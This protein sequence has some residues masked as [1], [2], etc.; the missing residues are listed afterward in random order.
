MPPSEAVAEYLE[1]LLALVLAGVTADT[2]VYACGNLGGGDADDVVR[3]SLPARG[4]R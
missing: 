2:D 3:G 4:S 1:L